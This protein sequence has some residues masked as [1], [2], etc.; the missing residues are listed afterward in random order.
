MLNMMW[1]DIIL[2]QKGIDIIISRETFE[3]KIIQDLFYST[4]LSWFVV[5]DSWFYFAIIVTQE[6]NVAHGPLVLSHQHFCFA[7]TGHHV[8]MRCTC[9]YF[10]AKTYPN[11]IF[12]SDDFWVS[13]FSK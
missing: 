4:T 10:I 3:K 5:Y 11:S 6:S 7:V 12:I 13:A 1:Y 9:M 2:L 8:L